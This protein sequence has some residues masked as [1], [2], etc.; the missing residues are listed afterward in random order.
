MIE[1][2]LYEYVRNAYLKVNDSFYRPLT[3]DLIVHL[4]GHVGLDILLKTKLIEPSAYPSQY[5]LCCEP[6]GDY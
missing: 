4:I 6:K 1:Y 3:K 2:T 5:V